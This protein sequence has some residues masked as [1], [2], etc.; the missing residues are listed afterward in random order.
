MVP[1]RG[2]IYDECGWMDGLM[3]DV[4]KSTIIGPDGNVQATVI[5]LSLLLMLLL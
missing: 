5:L 3:D 2:G 4:M 1:K